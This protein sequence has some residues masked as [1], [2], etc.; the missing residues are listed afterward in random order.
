MVEGRGTRGSGQR[1]SWGITVWQG[2]RG[3]PAAEE[4]E[5][6]ARPVHDPPAFPW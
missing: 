6:P 3:G 1:A 4:G 5:P 2:G